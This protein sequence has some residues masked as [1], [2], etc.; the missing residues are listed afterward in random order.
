[1]P[2]HTDFTLMAVNCPCH[3]TPNSLTLFCTGLI[4]CAPSVGVFDLTRRNVLPF[5][6]VQELLDDFVDDFL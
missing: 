3:A 4:E 1:M 6:V 5:H 2:Q